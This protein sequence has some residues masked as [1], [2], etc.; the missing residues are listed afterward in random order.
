MRVRKS[1]VLLTVGA[2]MQWSLAA[3][4]N[5]YQPIVE[6]NAFGLKPPPAPVQEQPAEPPKPPS[7]VVLTGISNMFA[8]KRALLEITEPNQPPAKGQAAAAA[9]TERPILAEGEKAGDVEVLSIDLDKN[10]V[11][12]RNGNIEADLTFE[13][14]KSAATP[15]QPGQPQLGQPYQAGIPNAG[16]P[17]APGQPQNQPT[18]ISASGPGNGSG[19]TLMGGGATATNAA[20]SSVTTYGGSATTGVPSPLGTE[21]GLRTIPSRTMRTNPGDQQQQI[22]P[23]QQAVLMEAERIRAQ[24]RMRNS[25]MNGGAPP[26]PPTPITQEIQQGQPAPPPGPQ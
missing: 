25:R 24:Q 14:P 13:V 8:K 15:G 10:I 9:K 22:D 11:R 18:V 5:P 26:L 23:A 20:G 2:A 12:I 7:K 1:V 4:A 6:R 19:V 21:S 3:W 16:V 17:G